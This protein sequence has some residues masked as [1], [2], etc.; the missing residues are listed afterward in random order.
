MS[1]WD[2]NEGKIRVLVY[3]R[4][5]GVQPIKG[6]VPLFLKPKRVESIFVFLWVIGVG[7]TRILSN[8]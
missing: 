1:Y 2:K 8:N 6:I 4:R 7:T 5:R 3:R